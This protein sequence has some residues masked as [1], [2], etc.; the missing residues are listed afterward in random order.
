M[1]HQVYIEPRAAMAQVEPNG[2]VSVWTATQGIFPLRDNLARI[3]ACRQHKV[4]VV[5]TE[6]GGGFGGKIAQ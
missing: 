4:R 5:P 6:I 1:A 3:S 2:R